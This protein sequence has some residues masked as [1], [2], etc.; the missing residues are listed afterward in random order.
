[1]YL[2]FVYM[3][4]VYKNIKRYLFFSEWS[5]KVVD[6]ISHMD[7]LRKLIHYVM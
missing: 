4:D 7:H 3:L 2:F 5:F 6:L 1:M